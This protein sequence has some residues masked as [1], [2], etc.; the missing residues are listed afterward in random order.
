M[1]GSTGEQQPHAEPGGPVSY[2]TASPEQR[3]RL[4]ALLAEIDLDDPRSVLFFG[5]RAQQELTELSDRLL[6][7]VRNKDA[8]G[9]GDAL[10]A[11][12]GALRGFEP[13]RLDPK[14]GQGLLGRL[15]GRGP[16]LARV[17]QRY[18]E[19]RRQIDRI[20]DELETHKTQLL[21]DVVSLDRL[22]A[23]TLEY[24]RMLELY[25]AAGVEQL[26]RLDDEQRPAAE[27]AVQAGD[28]LAAQRV[29][30]LRA[31]RDDLER[32]VHDLR[33]TR[34]VAMQSLPS[35]RLVQENDKGLIGR[36]ES[37][38][39]NTV[40]L[41]RQQLA[42]A[43]TILRSGAAAHAVRAA[44]DLTNELLTANADQLRTANA[45]TRRQLER[46]VFDID[47][48]EH[49]NRQLVATI[50]ESLQIAAE[51][52]RARAEATQQLAACEAELRRTLVSAGER[53]ERPAGA[54]GA[55][56]DTR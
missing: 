56:P 34:Q 6:E 17:L 25:L 44:S 51:G 19:V 49:A 14:R 53:A 47:A 45:E 8:E 9:A 29:R 39:V 38:L 36:I 5:S 12:V 41:W 24:F 2:A 22:Y 16:S 55:E 3:A 10:G 4:D 7:G 37:V 33:L 52:R 42:T 27:R 50:E 31:V 43:V 26:R 35:L 1:S 20:G 21:T 32:R 30:D 18:E 46:G 48:V 15:L 23:T 13:A 40:P 54:P 11:M 28:V